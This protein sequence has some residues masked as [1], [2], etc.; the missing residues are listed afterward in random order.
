[1]QLALLGPDFGDV[2]VEEADGVGLE[3]FADG[4]VALGLR[5]PRTAMAL[6]AAMQC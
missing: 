3:A 2:D 6:E 5:E 1:V 4:L